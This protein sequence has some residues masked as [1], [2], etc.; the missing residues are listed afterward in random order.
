MYI[1]TFNIKRLW[2]VYHW[3][4]DCKGGMVLSTQASWWLCK[5]I[6]TRRW[7]NLPATIWFT[8]PY[9][10]RSCLPWWSM[11]TRSCLFLTVYTPL[12][13]LWYHLFSHKFGIH[14]IPFKQLLVRALL[15]DLP[16]VDYHNLVCTFHRT[17]SVSNNYHCSA[18][19]V[20]VQGLLNLGKEQWC[21]SAM[22]LGSRP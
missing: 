22:H 17:Q 6:A 19:Q 20:S 10:T 15:Q 3:E 5:P 21:F 13:F 11:H 2:I 4:C 9:W 16:L 14:T 8:V 7:L 12:A 18:M 1:W